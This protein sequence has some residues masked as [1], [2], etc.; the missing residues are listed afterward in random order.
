MKNLTSSLHLMIPDP[1]E[2][3]I[4]SAAY[5]LWLESGCLSGRELDHWLAAKELMRHRHGHEGVRP[6]SKRREK[7]SAVRS[8]ARA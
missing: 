4:Q 6:P 1:T 2:A 8:L 5:H 3:E 7:T